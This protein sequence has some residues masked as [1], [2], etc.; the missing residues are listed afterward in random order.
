VKYHLEMTIPID[1]KGG[2]QIVGQF[3]VNVEG[4][5]FNLPA[6]AL[7]LGMIEKITTIDEV[8]LPLI[9]RHGRAIEKL[10]GVD[11][12][13]IPKITDITDTIEIDIGL[14]GIGG[15]R[16]VIE[17]IDDIIAITVP[18]RP[19]DAG[20]GRQEE[21]RGDKQA[22]RRDPGQVVFKKCRDRVHA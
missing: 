9:D 4:I 12:S 17:G 15:F 6:I 18:N 8:N 11:H 20:W 13:G 2:G 22:T 19:G 7:L 3:S 21:K 1:L 14:I 16:A 10:A 5:F